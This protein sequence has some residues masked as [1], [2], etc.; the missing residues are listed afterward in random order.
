MHKKL[1]KMNLSNPKVIV[2]VV[3]LLLSSTVVIFFPMVSE[4][5]QQDKPGSVLKLAKASVSIDIPISKGYIDGNIAYFIATDASDKHAV[6]SI[7][8]NT[9]FPINY[10]PLLNNT[11]ESIRGQGYVFLNGMQGEEL[12]GFQLPVANAVPGDK[13][14]SPLWQT[15]FV[16]WNDNATARELKSVEEIIA[17]QKNGEL[18]ITETNII[19]NS[20]AIKW[21]DGSLK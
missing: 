19:V 20:P 7:T 2:V 15:N 10:A 14:Y 13:D 16:K 4:Q 18:T 12:G 21:Q 17:A 6:S 1:N 9:G 5:Q 8:N 3:L 11:P